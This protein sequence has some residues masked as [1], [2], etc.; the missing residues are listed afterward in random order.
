MGAA[1]AWLTSIALYGSFDSQDKQL[2]P[3]AFLLHAVF[4]SIGFVVA[5]AGLHGF[6]GR[7][8]AI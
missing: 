5:D 7:A 1:V 3:Q 4:T 8:R 6:R 2:T